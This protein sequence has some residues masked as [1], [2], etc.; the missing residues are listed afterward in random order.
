MNG[1]NRVFLMGYL[2]REPESHQSKSGKNYVRLSL[3]THF[4]KKLETGEKEETTTWHKITVFGKTAERCQSN[5]QKGDP[6][7]VEGYLSQYKYDRED[8]GEATA[9]SV[10]AQQIH[11]IGRRSKPEPEPLEA[12]SPAP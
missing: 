4:N 9:H 8:G 1:I 7:A 10:V 6:F 3:A 11:F 2:G 12:F 5:L